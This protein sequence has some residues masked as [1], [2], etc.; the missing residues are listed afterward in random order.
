M[1]EVLA[2]NYK[3]FHQEVSGFIPGSRLFSDPFR[4]LAYGTDASFYR[5]IPKIVILVK[6]PDEMSRILN[7]AGRLNVPVTFRAAGTSLSGQAV[8]DSVLLVTS[9]G[10]KK[11]EV[12]GNGELI[13]LEPGVIGAQANAYLVPHKRKIGPDPASISSCLIGGIAANNASGMCCGT[14][15]NSY[16]TVEGMKIIFSDGS[17]LDTRDPGSRLRFQESHKDL[18]DEIGRIRDEIKGDA[19][20]RQRI[21]DKYRIKNTT[22]YSLNAFVDYNDPI[23]IILHL[24]I[25]SEGTLGFISEIT[26]ATVVEHKHKASALI[27]FPDIENACKATIILKGEPTSAVE[28]MDR[29][30][31]R[32]VEDREG[33]PS[34]LKSLDKEAAALLV[35]TRAGD[36]DALRGQID[37]I[38]DSLR[39]IPTVLPVAFTDMKAEYEKLWD[40]RRGLFPAVGAARKIGTTVIIEDVAFP[41]EKLASATVEL[42]AL[43]KKHGYSEGIIFGHARDGN[44]HFVFTQDFNYPEEVKRYQ[45]FMDDVCNMVVKKYDGSLKAEHGTGR[46]MAPFVELEWGRKAYDLMKR[47]KKAFDPGNILN[48]GVMLNN[49]PVAHIENLKPLPKTNELVDRCIEC[50]F[51]EVKCPSRNI[52]ATPRQRIVVQREISRLRAAGNGG[53]RL[54]ALEKSYTYLGEQ[55]C[56]GDGLCATACPVAIDTGKLTKYL[57]SLNHGPLSHG[58]AGWVV[59]HYPLVLSGMRYGLKAA[60]VMH[61]VLGA[62]FMERISGFRWNRHM[63]SGISTPRFKDVSNGADRTVVYFPSCIARTMGPSKYDKDQRNIFEATLSILKKAGYNV[64]FPEGMEKLCCGLPFESKGFFEQADR[65]SAELE[66]A[67]LACGGDTYPVL[68]DTS[69]CLYRMRNAFTSGLKIYEPVEFIHT[70]LM[71]RLK[72]RKAPDTVAVHVTCSSVKM[73]LAEKFRAVAEACSAKVIIPPAVGCCG[74][75]GDRGF[76]Y[77]ELN[78]SALAELRGSIP[79]DCSAGYSNSRTCEIGLTR[80]SGID[81]QSIVYLVDKCT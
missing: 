25:G 50:G 58:M 64:V 67:L 74:F 27:I 5:L 76:S 21:I 3:L 10:W 22:G 48:P 34:Y 1:L 40:I 80:H 53:E 45:S 59:D 75:A 69:P 44:L 56:A 70:F 72:F 7:S 42:Q 12:H 32:S 57:R 63:P 37:R 73:G 15:Q 66:K 24:M 52:T 30:S 13:T 51:C 17:V 26:Y 49:N 55:T 11:F 78:E 54:K 19:A 35:E 18:L 20:L 38:M 79:A 16:Q 2:G 71:E 60:R 4:S 41:I 61:T 33:M 6:T 47:T 8:T 36:P 14:A 28:L 43:M 77:P 68:C 31:L 81:Y 9:G 39:A 65:M 29:A 62:S 23:D 46:N